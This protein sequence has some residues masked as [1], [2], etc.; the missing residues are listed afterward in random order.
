MEAHRKECPLE[1]HMI[2]CEYHNVGCKR[3]LLLKDLEE[4]K[5]QKMEEHLMMT[6]A[7]LSTTMKQVNNLTLLMNAQL[8]KSTITADVWPVHLDAIATMF[9]LGNQ[10]CPVAIKMEEYNDKKLIRYNG[11]VTPSTLTTRDTRCV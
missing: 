2:Q 8:S 5:K 4:H 1:M 10:V 7:Q 9:K 11:T 6:T 3:T